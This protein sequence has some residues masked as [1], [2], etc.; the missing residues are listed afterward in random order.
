M[1]R[2]T[3]KKRIEILGIDKSLY[4]L[5]GELTAPYKYILQKGGGRTGYWVI[6]EIGDR[7]E[8]EHR[9]EYMT[10]DDVCEAFYQKMLEL[11]KLR[12]RIKSCEYTP[13]KPQQE[14]CF[15]VNPSGEVVEKN[16]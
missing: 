3:L 14:R 1:K 8:E 11:K 13:V 7:G 9:S 4:S 12:E 2:N 6:I 16:E 10:E 15:I 5:D